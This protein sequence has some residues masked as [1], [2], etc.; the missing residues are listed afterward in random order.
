MFRS[1]STVCGKVV[2]KSVAKAPW[3]AILGVEIFGAPDSDP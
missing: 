3:T 2:R 1:D